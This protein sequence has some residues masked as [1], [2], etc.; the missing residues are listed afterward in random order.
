MAGCTSRPVEP[1]TPQ[2]VV[3]EPV[4]PPLFE[5]VS[6]SSGIAFTCR[7]GEEANHL[8]ILETLGGGVAL[9][10]YDGDG[11]LDVFLV[12]GGVY[13]GKDK[14][15]IVGSPC[16][17]YRN[18]GGFK[19]KD[20]TAEVG[21]DKLAGGK[22]WFYSQGAAVAD[23][24]RDG[25]PDL[26]VTGWGQVAL[27]RNVPVDPRD[28][29]KGRRF[30][31]VTA[32]AGLDQGITWATSAAFGDL[33]GDGYPDLYICQYVNWSWANH[34]RC[35]FD[36]KTPEYCPPRSFAGLP[37]KVYRNNGAGRFVD[38]SQTA[39]LV[40]P[41][42]DACK[43][44]GVLLID[45]DGDGRPDVLVA[46]DLTDRL[47]YHNRSTPGKIR[48]QEVGMS[49]GVARDD[50][51]KA[52]GSMGVDGGDYNG[53]GRPSLW[54]TNFEYEQHGL[55]RN[56]CRPGRLLF[57]HQTQAAGLTVL[58]QRSVAWGTGFLDVDL[59]G[60][61]DLFVVNGHVYRNP[62]GGAQRKQAPLLWRNL[63][64]KFEEISRQIGSYQSRPTLARGVGLGDLD[65]DGRI[66]L[67]ISHLNEPVTILRG[68]GGAGKHWLG[69]ELVGKDHADVVGA[70]GQLRVGGRSLTRF[71]KGGSS[72]L[73][74]GDRRLV[75]G[76]G[77]HT[78]TGPLTITW[79]D[80][81]RQQLD[82]LMC[83]RYYRITQGQ[84]ARPYPVKR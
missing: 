49:S 6:A 79:P 84:G 59:D 16:K 72:Y 53:S 51:G 27:F 7:N 21:L 8:A 28:P 43:G 67:V 57:Q 81:A 31:D 83:D 14:K 77:E 82:D 24:D 75:F 29:S 13:A 45:V 4:G 1:V 70:R 23:Y 68:I 69:L 2:P 38:V 12:G 33:D 50:Q 9:L 80:G 48:F 78:Q 18:L 35:G 64:G 66:D 20:V 55:F 42:P 44:L 22:P 41:G 63:G 47:L 30:V 17:L 62:G 73:S 32:E 54:V 52:N 58:S 65:N 40:P 37:H 34:P 56:D 61:E 5:D 71:V 26:L 10:D 60:W 39:G 19:F 76:L 3:E 25:W 15:D 11:L 74:S 36:E 46:N